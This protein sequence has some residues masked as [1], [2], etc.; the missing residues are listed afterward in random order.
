MFTHA[1]ALLVA[2]LIG[3]IGL[4]T[5]CST[6]G[7]LDSAATTTAVADTPPPDPQDDITT[8]TEDQRTT[9][10][11]AGPTDRDEIIDELTE[12]FLDEPSV[13]FEDREVARCVATE[14]VD[15]VGE[16]FDDIDFDDF[17][18][19]EET[20]LSFASSFRE[21]GFD[22]EGLLA[23]SLIEGGA[24]R[25]QA[26]CVI[27]KFGIDNIEYLFALGMT[28]GDMDVLEDDL[29]AAVEACK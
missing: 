12:A 14:F 19:D 7:D 15:I 28:D 8:I 21:C 3:T 27:E 2:A 29:D 11:D 24:T 9:T 10:T 1:R 22:T 13:P 26:E 18:M 4:V 6:S 5:A 17:E 16:N 23:D 25:E 20:A